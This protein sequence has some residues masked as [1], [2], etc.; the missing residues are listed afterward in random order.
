M[1]VFFAAP[2]PVS[3]VFSF[4]GV[5]GV[6]VRVRVR[7]TVRVRVRVRVLVSLHI[8]HHSSRLAASGTNQ[9]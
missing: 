4:W 7:V 9:G 1:C 5:V 2:P 6:R 3:F 8:R